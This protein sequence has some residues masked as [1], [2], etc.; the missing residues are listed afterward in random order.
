MSEFDTLKNMLDRNGAKFVVGTDGE[1]NK[2][3]T[4][5]ACED[6]TLVFGFNKNEEMDFV[7]ATDDWAECLEE[8]RTNRVPTDEI[9]NIYL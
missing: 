5:P 1:G 6:E 8:L 9:Y 7:D 2:I 4:I 3:I